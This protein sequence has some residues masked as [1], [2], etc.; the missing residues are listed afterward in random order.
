LRLLYLSQLVPYPVD[1]GPKVRQYHVLQYLAAAGH[2][3]TLLAF[4]RESDTAE[5][6]DHLRQF[7]R[8]V[9]TVPMARSRVRDA[10]HLARSLLTG[11]PFLIARD[12][13]AAMR[14]KVSELIRQQPFDA[15][16]ADQ[17]WMAQYA[18]TAAAAAPDGRPRLVL[19]Q[20]NAMYLIP[21][22]LAESATN[23]L[24]RALLRREAN[25][26]R[27]YERATCRRFDHVV[28]VTAEDQQAV[29][30]GR[31]LARQELVI[32][33]CVD[34]QARPVIERV[35]HP[36]R[37]TFLGGLH[38]PPNAAGI[39]WFAREVWPRVLAKC[40]DAVLTV[41]GKN[42]PAELSHGPSS[43]VHRLELTGYVD[44]PTPYLAETAVF[45]VPLHAGG[46]MRVKI[47]DAWCWGLPVV[48]TAIGAEGIRYR[49]GDDLLIADTAADF[50]AAV[51]R[52]WQAPEMANHL[53]TVG[54]QTVEDWYDWRSIYRDWD[55]VYEPNRLAL[56]TTA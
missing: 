3:I 50:A 36:F 53:G 31:P 52:L 54:R 22:R 49:D 28:W 26:M 42:P 27:D 44:D 41:I 19:D 48:S 14:A 40:P 51:V 5:N 2:D 39:I 56:S 4:R 20:H 35:A 55:N 23:P 7:C 33:I 16:H 37:V 10:Y 46:G 29:T 25:V 38:W 9:H 47:L 34:P 21:Q 15:I 1:A 43:I 32:P 18:L 17:L 13:V 45:I 8:E 11:I 30:G 12:D 24:Q 6:I